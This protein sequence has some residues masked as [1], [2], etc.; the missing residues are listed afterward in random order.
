MSPHVDAVRV[1]RVWSACGVVRIAV[2][3]RE[4]TVACADCGRES[5][6]VHSRYSRT[7]ADVAL[8]GRPVLIGLTVRRLFCDRSRARRHF[9][10]CPMSSGTPVLRRRTA[11]WRRYGRTSS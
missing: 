6:R 4:L 8:G 9:S 2:R 5:A 10:W 7:P 3:A 1:E 11:S